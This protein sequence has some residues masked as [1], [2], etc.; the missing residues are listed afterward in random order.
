MDPSRDFDGGVKLEGGH[1][2]APKW[3]KAD[4]VPFRYRLVVGDLKGDRQTVRLFLTPES[5][6]DRM[7]FLAFEYRYVRAR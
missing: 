5:G 2:V 1:F 4:N 7:E 3:G 6:K